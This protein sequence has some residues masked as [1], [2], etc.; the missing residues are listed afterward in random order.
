MIRDPAWIHIDFGGLDPDP[1]PREQ[2]L[3]SKINKEEIFM[4]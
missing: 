1:I 4:F 2:K 3:L